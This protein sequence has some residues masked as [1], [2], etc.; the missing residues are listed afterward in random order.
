M[1]YLR[2]Y[3]LDYKIFKIMKYSTCH[4]LGVWGM[5]ATIEAQ[6]NCFYFLQ[7]LHLQAQNLSMPLWPSLELALFMAQTISFEFKPKSDIVVSL[8]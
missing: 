4:Y 3:I 5:T 8:S 7:V 1:N 6:E 2:K